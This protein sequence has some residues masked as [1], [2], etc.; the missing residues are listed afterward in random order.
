MTELT[1]LQKLGLR[2]RT[3]KPDH[4]YDIHIAMG[5]DGKISLFIV[6]EDIGK[7]EIF[8]TNTETKTNAQS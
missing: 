7:L 5:S 8:T 2:L 6:V 3:L 4:L 1:D